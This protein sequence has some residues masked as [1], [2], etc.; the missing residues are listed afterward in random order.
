MGE[1]RGKTEAAVPHGYGYGYVPLWCILPF[2]VWSRRTKLSASCLV[3]PTS[4]YR[5][6]KQNI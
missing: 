2:R 6:E 5:N 3:H 1:C 4:V